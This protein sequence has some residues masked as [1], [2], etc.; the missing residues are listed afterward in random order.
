M[1]ARL[2]RPNYVTPTNYLE[3][4]KGYC[5]L[6]G[7]KRGAVGDQANKLK[8]G[9]QK[10]S[11]TAVQ[12]GE[13]SL[14]LEQKKKVVAKAQTETEELLVVIVQENHVVAEQQKQVN[15]ESDKIGKDEVETRKIAD[16][17][18]QDLDKAL[19][20]LEAAQKALE[21]LN[22]KDIGEVK[23]YAKPHKAVE[24]TLEAVMVLRR[25]EA[26]WAEAKKQMNDPSFLTQ[27][28]NYDKDGLNDQ[29]LTK[30]A[31]Y[32]K[33]AEFDP[34]IVG[35][36]SKA[37]KSLCMWVRAMETYGRIA[38]DVAPKRA[39]LQQA[40]K[41]LQKKQAQLKDMQDK[42]QEIND[43]VQALQDQYNEGS[44][45]KEELVNDARTLEIKMERA[46][47]L[48]EGLGGERARWEGSIA[49]LDEQLV[50][51]VGDCLL[52]AAFLSYCGPFDSDYRHK[53]LKESW[54]KGV[55]T[56]NIPCSSGFDFC[57]FLANNE[58]V[59]DWNSTRTG[60]YQQALPFRII[61]GP[62][63]PRG[64]PVRGLAI[65]PCRHPSIALSLCR[66]A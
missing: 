15:I 8:N 30:V 29:V 40:M 4:V 2:G 6:L 26:S 24:K 59:R 39:K 21:L 17:A 22:K 14:E 65:P 9:L 45:K 41:T 32:T 5:K 60:A 56:L 13:M 37:A 12:V 16:D 20:A 66:L 19:P 51:L 34:E 10:L 42:V 54:L 3:L 44:R 61:L 38:K 27:L 23:A 50:N 52:A 28:I 25:S 63:S 7:E 57:N 48:V 64:G 55:R 62:V 49:G 1:L 33:E 18:Q 53:L 35:A 58:D 47:S 36:V 46:S 31:R 43:K 11:D